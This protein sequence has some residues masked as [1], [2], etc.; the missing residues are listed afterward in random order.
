MDAIDFRQSAKNK[1]AAIKLFRMS[2]I[3][4]LWTPLVSLV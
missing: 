2:V 1:M 3:S 4:K